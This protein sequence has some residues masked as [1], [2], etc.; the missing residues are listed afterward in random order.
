MGMSQPNPEFMGQHPSRV[1]NFHSRVGGIQESELV[2]G[3]C[4]SMGSPGPR[5]AR[6][7][8]PG[9]RPS[10]DAHCVTLNKSLNLHQLCKGNPH[11]CP[12]FLSEMLWKESSDGDPKLGFSTSHENSQPR[13]LAFYA[14]GMRIKL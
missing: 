3:P 6:R 4:Y 12:T 14:S 1:G 5:K 8:F 2:L 11:L 13:A 7:G 10:S 9:L